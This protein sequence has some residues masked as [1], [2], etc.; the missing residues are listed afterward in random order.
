MYEIGKDALPELK[1]SEARKAD[2]KQKA[3]VIVLASLLSGLLITAA[4]ATNQ[5]V[6][7][8]EKIKEYNEQL[9]TEYINNEIMEENSKLAKEYSEQEKNDDLLAFYIQ[10]AKIKRDGSITNPKFFSYIPEMYK[11]LI[12]Y[13]KDNKPADLNEYLKRKIDPENKVKFEAEIWRIKE[14]QT[15]IQNQNQR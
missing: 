10:N 12:I 13:I 6:S 11:S 7:D 5:N 3:K 15:I 9:K 1:V 4:T 8:M 2:R 14:N